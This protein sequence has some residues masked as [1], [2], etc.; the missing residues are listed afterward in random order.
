[1]KRIWK[2]RQAMGKKSLVGMM[3][4]LLIAGIAVAEEEPTKKLDDM[5][6]T[7]TRTEKTIKDLPGSVT[8]ITRNEIEES[9]AKAVPELINKLPGVTVYDSS[10]TGMS[11][12]VSL[13]GVDPS[14]C[15]KVL[16][17]VN[18]VP[19]NSGTTGTVF[20]RDLPAPEQIERIEVVK[21]PVSALYGGYGLGGCIN[22]ITRRGP[23]A[24]K[25]KIET[26]FGSDHERLYAAET[27]GNIKEK[28][29]YQLGYNYHEGDGFRD[30]SEFESHKLSTKLGFI[31]TDRADIELDLGYSEL[32]YDVPGRLTKAQYEEDPEQARS[33]FGRGDLQRSYSNLTFRQDI[34]QDDNLKATFYYHTYELDY[35]FA[36]S[37][38]KNYIYDVYTTGGEVQYTL[39]HSIW[40]RNNRLIFGPTIT[41]HHAG[42]LAYATSNGEKVGNPTTDTLAKPL[43]WGAYIQDEFIIFDPLTLTLGVRYDKAEFENEDRL[44]PAN[45]GET[46]T[47]AVSPKFGLA[48]RLFEH[49]TLFANIAKGFAPP[50]VSKLFGSAGNPDLKPETSINYELSVRTAPL[51]WF[52][53]TASIYQMDV[54]DE[55]IREGDFYENAGEARHRGFESELNI[56]LPKGFS[57]FLNFTYQNVEYT[58]YPGYDGKD[59]P[60]TPRKSFAAGIKYRHPVGLNFSLSATY[61]DEKYSDSANQYKIPGYTVWDTR[62]EFKNRFKGL[63]YSVH[64]SVRNLFDEE[65]YASGYRDE[66]YPSPPRTFL[67]GAGVEF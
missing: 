64:A 9:D 15:N 58:D 60:H 65:Y 56:R 66:A 11:Y 28:F 10:G 23:I 12:S 46:S 34:G 32:D 25:T 45:S 61:E 63:G 51:D 36:T 2:K 62:L 57:P 48:Y 16:V 14:R 5:V 7:A 40:G 22:I 33:Q 24:P 1:M 26:S 31:L 13:R 43:F 52:D 20:W 8:A 4:A 53:L 44:D 29:S 42:T 35:V 18:G 59:L 50:S 6:V 3:I 39:N 38:Y 21:G 54:Q 67:V 47:D 19:M 17:M 55:I 37:P 30:R 41:Y 49:T 27:G